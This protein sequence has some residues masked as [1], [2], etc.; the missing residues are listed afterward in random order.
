MLSNDDLNALL[1]QEVP[2]NYNCFYFLC[3]ALCLCNGYEWFAR[4]KE[5]YYYNDGK[6]RDKKLKIMSL[7][8]KKMFPIEKL[9][10]FELASERKTGDVVFLSKPNFLHCGLLIADG[11]SILHYRKETG[12]IY[13]SYPLFLEFS[14][15]KEKERFR[16]KNDNP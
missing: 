8:E 2:L 7:I 14:G 13:Q 10:G 4:E 6:N 12:P 16:L 9:P 5:L 15:F 1:L 3:D 11:K